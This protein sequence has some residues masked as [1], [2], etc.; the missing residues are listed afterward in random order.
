VLTAFAVSVKRCSLGM[1]DDVRTACCLSWNGA[2]CRGDNANTD[3]VGRPATSNVSIVVVSHSNG[4]P[5]MLPSMSPTFSAS[6]ALVLL[7]LPAMAFAAPVQKRHIYHWHGYG[8]LPGYHQP[9]NN[10]V[11]I[12][13]PKGAIGDGPDTAPSYWYDGGRY[14]FGRPGFFRGHYNGGSF[15]PCWTPTPIGPMWNCG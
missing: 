14:Y 8:F 10:N 12:Y 2:T 13:G 15:G 7:L 11:P 6:S 1:P 5:C 9:P 3:R 4:R